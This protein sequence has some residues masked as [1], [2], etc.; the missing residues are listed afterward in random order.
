MLFLFSSR[1]H[2]ETIITNG[3]VVVKHKTLFVLFS[4]LL[5]FLVPPFP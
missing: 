2:A 5:A 4:C 3:A 1:D